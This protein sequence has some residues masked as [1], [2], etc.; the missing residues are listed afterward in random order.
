MK[1]IGLILAAAIA[2]VFGLLTIRQGG[3]VL[4]GDG[5]ARSDADNY[6][7]FVLWFNF[8]A[9]FA[10]VAA[11]V[12]FWF[13]RPWFAWLA[14]SIAIATIIVFIAFGAYVLIG[15]SHEMRTVWAMTARSA[16]WIMLAIVVCRGHTG[17]RQC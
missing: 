4:F 17:L 3:M 8:V 15:E 10:Y 9:G 5:A 6:V 13:L 14:L 2:I 11:G 1:S 7:P 12:G 16:I